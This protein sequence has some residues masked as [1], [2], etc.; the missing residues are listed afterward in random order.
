MTL[1]ELSLGMPLSAETREHYFMVDAGGV[2]RID[3]ERLKGTAMREPMTL[4]ELISAIKLSGVGDDHPDKVS[5]AVVLDVLG[6]LAQA[7]LEL[8][9]VNIDRRD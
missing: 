8:D 5:T 3:L 4:E 7:L 2:R 6:R 9:Q 1:E